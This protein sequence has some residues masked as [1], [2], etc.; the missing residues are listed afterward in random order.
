[1]ADLYQHVRGASEEKPAGRRRRPGF[2][3]LLVCIGAAVAA[4]AVSAVWF[5]GAR[6]RFYKFVGGLSN[7]TIYA[8]EHDSLHAS[9]QGREL[10]VSGENAYGIYN[11]LSALGPDT[12][13]RSEPKIQADVLLDYG[14]GSLLRVWEVYLGNDNGFERYG[15]LFS[16]QGSDGSRYIYRSSRIRLGNILTRFLGDEGN[17]PWAE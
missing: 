10:R 13:K 4:V 1:M 16:F 12:E 11:Y 8:Y 7:A 6:P 3:I 14:D 5:G 2:V 17:E 9:V 15:T